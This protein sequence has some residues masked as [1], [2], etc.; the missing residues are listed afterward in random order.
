MP[1]ARREGN[2]PREALAL[3]DS[4]SSLAS[5]AGDLRSGRKRVWTP[6]DLR[7]CRSQMGRDGRA[8]EHIFAPTAVKQLDDDG[9]D[10]RDK[11]IF[12]RRGCRSSTSRRPGPAPSPV[13]ATPPAQP[14]EGDSHADLIALLEERARK[15]SHGPGLQAAGAPPQRRVGPG[16]LRDFFALLH[17]RR[18][19]SRLPEVAGTYVALSCE[20][21][22]CCV[23]GSER[24]V[25]A[26]VVDARAFEM[27]PDAGLAAA[28]SLHPLLAKG[29]TRRLLRLGER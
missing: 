11:R 24:Q 12:F 27:K 10:A 2:P 23:T 29:R 3:D 20:T 1:G 8:V 22:P 17:A 14:I 4:R 18:S 9:E 15:V 5:L 19:A 16:A 13:P 25:V 28:P 26:R 6:A 21:N 7:S